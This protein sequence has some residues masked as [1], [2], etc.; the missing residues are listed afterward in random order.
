M[1]FFHVNNRSVP[2]KGILFD[3]DG[4]LLDFMTMW[5]AWA[6]LV[7]CGMEDA[8]ALEGSRFSGNA[9]KLL[10]TEHD[11]EGRV[12]GYD[13]GGP[14][15]MATT[16]ET[17]GILAWQLYS[18]GVPWNDALTRVISISSEAM[19]E[20]R[21]RRIAAPLR[22]LLP[23]LQQCAGASLKLGVV[24]SD[25]SET[26]FE[27]LEWLGITSY[28]GSV[29]TRD[30]VNR[31]KPAPEMVELACRELGLAPHETILIG[32]SNADMQM[33]KAADLCL[34]VGI[35]GKDGRMEHLLNADTV[36]TDFT[37]LMITP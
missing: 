23:F 7:L 10:G 4:T 32:D 21:R 18:A 6:E 27:H 15:P 31:G 16:E 14:L 5:G 9:S 20:V 11:A 13:P 29:V 33:G 35:S 24:T 1:P 25:E 17:H 28:F 26:T 34:T 19:K 36:I 37:E 30:R 22:G 2:C 12:I 3:K 8:I